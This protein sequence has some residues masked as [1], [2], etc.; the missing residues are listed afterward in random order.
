MKTLYFFRHAKSSWDDS[1]LSDFD[2]EITCKG[3]GSIFSMVYFHKES[4]REANYVVS[5]PA[6]RAMQTAQIICEVIGYN[7]DNI[8]YRR[9]LYNASLSDVLQVVALLP[10]D[11]DYAI[12]VGHNPSATDFA[13]TFLPHGISNLPTSGAIRLVF[14]TD[15]WSDAN[16][17]NLIDSMVDYPK[18]H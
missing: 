18:N 13:N 9:S 2:R 5:S 4:L 7:V 1:N 15:I 8:D 6:V 3:S 12:I 17:K 10:N 14:D 11:S 16:R